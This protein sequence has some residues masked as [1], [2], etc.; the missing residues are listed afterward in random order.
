M[1][2]TQKAATNSPGLFASQLEWLDFGSTLSLSNGDETTVTNTTSDGSIITFKLSLTVTGNPS[3]IP[4]IVYQGFTTPTFGAAPFGN[5]AYVGIPGQIALY[6][7]ANPTIG[8]V[9]EIT[10]TLDEITL[11]DRCGQ[12]ISNYTLC[13]ADAETTNKGVT[14]EAEIWKITT[15]TTPWSLIQQIPSISGVT[16]A[17]PV[18]TGLGTQIAIE[19]GLL[20]SAS[21]TSANIFSTVAPTRLIAQAQVDGGREG[22]CFGLL[23]PKVIY[24]ALTPTAFN[25]I[26]WLFSDTLQTISFGLCPDEKVVGLYYNGTYYPLTHTG[27]ALTGRLGS[28]LITNQ[29]VVVTTLAGPLVD[30][31]DV[32][33]LHVQTPHGIT[34]KPYTLGLLA[35][36]F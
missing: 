2:S 17:G 33:T 30:T 22:F 4:Q 23:I 27:I 1:L 21:T 11:T 31:L 10:L 14:S 34:I 12:P 3:V 32:F 8:N 26:N 36:P 9:M 35:N 25:A 18:V 7:G 28:Y 16:T 20:S 19:T 5:T 13:V 29:N 24:P 6:T 15:N